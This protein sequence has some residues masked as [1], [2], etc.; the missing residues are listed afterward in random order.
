M[1]KKLESYFYEKYPILFE[2]RTKP[3]TE[4]CM[5][6]GIGIND[7]WAYLLDN[8]CQEIMKYTEDQHDDVNTFNKGLPTN[9]VPDKFLEKIPFVRFSQIKEKFSSLRIYYYGG[10]EYIQHI[11]NYTERL[12]SSI[13]EDCGRFDAT[14]GK[15]TKGW[16]H[17]I[18]DECASKT[19][20]FKEERGWKLNDFIY[21]TDTKIDQKLGDIMKEVMIEKKDEST[22]LNEAM[23]K[24][25]EV[26]N[27]GK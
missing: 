5:C 6:W 24:I 21:P 14:V 11:I 27:L 12:S 18:C 20:N 19:P 8:L 23:E 22:K 1:N 13:C 4:T 26:K 25:K 16:V 17:T 9:S 15:T 3:M 10:D 2:D 7:G